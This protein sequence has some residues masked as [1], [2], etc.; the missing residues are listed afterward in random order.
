MIKKTPLRKGLTVQTDEG[1]YIISHINR[2][3]SPPLVMLT[4]KYKGKF[5]RRIYIRANN[6]EYSLN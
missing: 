4:E 2:M 3:I 1:P 6:L 5:G